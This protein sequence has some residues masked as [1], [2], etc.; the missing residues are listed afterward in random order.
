MFAYHE[1]EGYKK[2]MTF[3]ANAFN[4]SDR[5][6]IASNV[7]SLIIDSLPSWKPLALRDEASG[8]FSGCRQLTDV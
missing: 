5:A 3:L 8:Y 2:S 1:N 4:L 6:T 7:L